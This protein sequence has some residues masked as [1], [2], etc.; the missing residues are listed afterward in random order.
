MN[1]ESPERLEQRLRQ[2]LDREAE[3]LDGA[4]LSRLRQARQQALDHAGGSGWQIW[5]AGGPG[6]GRVIGALAGIVT[7]AFGL[8]VWQQWQEREVPMVADDLEV[9]AG[10]DDLMFYRQLDFYLWLE[11]QQEAEESGAGR[12]T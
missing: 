8:M 12:S 9:L 5:F 3:G 11:R 10:S 6:I 1:R 4:T 7:L 2:A